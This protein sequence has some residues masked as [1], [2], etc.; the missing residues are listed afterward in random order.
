[1][2]DLPELATT[3]TALLD[4]QRADGMHP[5]AQFYVSRHGKVLVDGVIGES[6]PGR[7]LRADDVMLWYSSGK[8]LTAVAVLQC[9]ERGDLAL[10]DPIGRYVGGWAGGKERV[11]IRHALTHTG[12]FT[13]VG[14]DEP[15]DKDISYAETLSR[16]AAHPLEWEPGTEGGY[17]PSSAWKVLGAVVEEVDGRPID[18]YLADEV[19]VPAGMTGSRLGIDV[20][21]REALGERLVPVHWTGHAFPIPTRDGGIRMRPYHIEEIHNEAWHM[22]KVEP[23]GGFRGPAAD[24]GRFYES[25][26]GFGLAVLGP[27]TVEVLGAVHRYGVPDRYFGSMKTPWGLGVQVAGGLTGRV[28]RR[29]FGHNGMASSR[30]LCDP[31]LGLVAVLVCNGLTDPV[32][33]EQRMSGFFDAVYSALGEDAQRVRRRS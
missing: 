28:G 22:A 16:I 15:F 17:H 5:G 18:R 23:G 8:P 33:N 3:L 6:R 25:L 32:K 24:L 2:S 12:G 1:M 21:T 4:A 14:P 7:A 10:D 19:L 29:A 27:R 9:W 13:M 31:E 26:L 11:T 20:A 30:G